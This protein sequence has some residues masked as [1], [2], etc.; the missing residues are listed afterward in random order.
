MF[1]WL[2]SPQCDLPL[3]CPLQ[4]AQRRDA[5]TAHVLISLNGLAV[6]CV[7]VE[8]VAQYF[9]AQSASVLVGLQKQVSQW[10][11]L[12]YDTLSSSEGSL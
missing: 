9:P 5:L 11:G 10:I 2:P 4:L 6:T 8:S 1:G 12:H 7:S 3:P